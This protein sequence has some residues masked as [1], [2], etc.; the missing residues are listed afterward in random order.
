MSSR[1]TR[2]HPQN[3][4]KLPHAQS[5]YPLHAHPTLLKLSTTLGT[6]LC[7]HY[8]VSAPFM[9]R[10]L[11]AR[12][13]DCTSAPQVYTCPRWPHTPFADFPITDR[14]GPKLFLGAT[15]HISIDC[16][17]LLAQADPPKQSPTLFPT[18]PLPLALQLHTLHTPT[19]Q[20]PVFAFNQDLFLPSTHT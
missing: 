15:M 7:I 18:P 9:W 4:Q 11:T 17:A 13:F 12:V 5:P 6:H 8:P 14:N 10:P 3:R 19:A 1:A 16:F 20:R 2:K